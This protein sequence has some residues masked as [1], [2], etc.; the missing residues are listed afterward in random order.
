MRATPGHT[1]VPGGPLFATGH[2]LTAMRGRVPGVPYTFSGDGVSLHGTVVTEAHPGEVFDLPYVLTGDP[3][4]LPLSDAARAARGPGEGLDWFPHLVVMLPGYECHPLGPAAR[5]PGALA[6]LVE[7]IVTWS[8]GRGLR[9]VAFLYTPPETG[10]LQRVLD[11]RGFRRV[12]LSYR[13]EL[14]VPAGG[15]PAYLDGLPAKR[16]REACRELRQLDAAGVKL[17]VSEI[18]RPTPELVAL[19]CGHSTKWNGGA[20]PVAIA[21][22]L[23]DLCDQGALL[24]G[25]EHDG[26]LL[27]YG[28]FLAHGDTWYCVS[29]ARAY[30]CA[31][32][33]H[34]Y[35]ATLFYEPVRHAAVA[36]VTRLHYGHGSWQAKISRGCRADELP[37]WVLALDPLLEDAVAR[38][39]ESTRLS[40]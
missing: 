12:P 4:E 18:S 10:E 39:A 40:A 6:A 21:A 15:F 38:S 9:A 11:G 13:C 8:A 29:T 17:T 37:A 3:P 35:F 20:D 36:G 27:G 33:R 32:A 30:G 14:P 5:A 31:Q 1:P 23:G 25:A 22:R 34:T 24:F 19:K 16:R 26:A 28:L 2:W 7:D